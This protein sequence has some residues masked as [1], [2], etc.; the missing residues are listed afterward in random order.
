MKI[1]I[2]CSDGSPIG[3]TSKTLWGDS[4]R[5]G[6]GGSEYALITM[7]E[8]WTKRGYEVTLYN[9][10]KEVGVSPFHQLPTNAFN[11]NHP[12]DVL[13]TFRS[14][15]PLSIIAKGLKVWWS[16]D[17]YTI[18]N[19][20]NFAPSMNRI[21]CISDFHKNYFKSQYNI[22]NAT[23]IDLPVR[24]Q[25]FPSDVER[26]P[27]RLVFTSVPDRGLHY[28]LDIWEEVKKS[29]PDVNLYITS[30][31]RLW[32]APDPRNSRHRAGWIGQKDV[33]FAGALPRKRYV[34]ELAKSQ[35]LV[36]P[37]EYEELFCISVAE[38]MISGVYP[39]TSGVGALSTTN[40]GTIIPHF[41]DKIFFDDMIGEVLFCLQNKDELKKRQKSIVNKA[42]KR[43]H[44][45][46]IIEEWEEKVFK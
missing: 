39:I 18:G 7:C 17:Q 23:V 21:V 40:M 28:L 35:L 36:Y 25:D 34:E 4:W 22:L 1:D 33:M 44:P 42:K 38:A 9:S 43:F 26:V 14:P 13:I 29:I 45:D 30:D 10:P 32:G 5:V 20:Q 6:V 46:R 12:R 24:I 19:F 16:C 31:Y 37:C 2:L 3:V 27:N 8:E 15:N 11:P 41:P